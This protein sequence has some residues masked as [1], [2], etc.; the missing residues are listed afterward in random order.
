LTF[1]TLVYIIVKLW[2]TLLCF[3]RWTGHPF[4]VFL[5]Q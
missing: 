1:D 4:R 5:C 2:S 3:C